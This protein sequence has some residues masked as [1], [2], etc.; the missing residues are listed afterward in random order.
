VSIPQNCADDCADGVG[1]DT[2]A[3]AK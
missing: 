2:I 3:F 1:I